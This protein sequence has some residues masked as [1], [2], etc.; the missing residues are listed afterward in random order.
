MVNFSSIK[1]VR[2]IIFL[3]LFDYLASLIV[4]KVCYSCQDVCSIESDCRLMSL[5]SFP[6]MIFRKMIETWLLLSLLGFCSRYHYYFFDDD[7]HKYYRG[8]LFCPSPKVNSSYI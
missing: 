2:H 7:G 5:D 8:K 1:N 6:L 3:F 4:A